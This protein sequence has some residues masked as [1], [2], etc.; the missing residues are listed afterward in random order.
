MDVNIFRIHTGPRSRLERPIADAYV[1]CLQNSDRA[2][3]G[4]QTEQRLNPQPKPNGPIL[5]CKQSSM[6]FKR[7]L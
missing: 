4:K 5:Q 3:A 1:V 7:Y 6:F 2:L